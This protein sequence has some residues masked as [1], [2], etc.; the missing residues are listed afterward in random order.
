MVFSRQGNALIW[1]SGQERIQIES[2]GPSA[3]RV[4]GKLNS[5]IEDDPLNALLDPIPSTPE[6]EIGTEQAC[7]QN[8][9]LKAEISEYGVVRFVNSSTNEELLAEVWQKF[10]QAER[11]F[12]DVGGDFFRVQLK[13]KAYSDERFYGLGQYKHGKLDQKGCVLDLLQLN[14]EVSIPFLLSNRGYGFLWNNPAVGRVELGENQTRWIAESTAKLDYWITAGDTPAQIVER[15]VD[16]T[17]HPPLLP[18]WAAG[19]WQCKLR[20]KSQDEL[21]DI[22]RSYKKR[23]LPLSVIVIDYFH[24]TMQGDWKFDSTDW[25]D[26]SAMVKE[27]EEMG[28]K[29]M[30]SVWP[31]VNGAS[32]NYNTMSQNGLMVETNRG[33]PAHWV[34]TDTNSPGLPAPVHFY[35]ATN[36][37]AQTFI[38]ERIREGYYQH[39]IK[40]YWLDACEPEMYPTDPENLR[41][42]LGNGL[43]VTNIYPQ[44]HA[45]AFYEGLKSEGE[46]EIITLCRSAWAGSQKYGAAVWSGDIASTFEALQSQVRAGLNIGLS[47]IPW[48]TTDIG[49]FHGGDP[50]SPYFREL[51]IRWFQYGVF[52]PLFRLHGFR[53]PADLDRYWESGGPNEV[54]SF[55][56]E[57]YKIITD[58]L[59]LRERLRPYIME[60]MS[61]AH[62][63]G[64]PPMRPLFYDFPDD[65]EAWA[66]EDQYM[67]GPDL[68]VAP[69][70][71]EGARSR[72]VYLP[73]GTCWHDAWTGKILGAGYVNT[74][75]ASLNHIPLYVRGDTKLPILK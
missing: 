31:T 44:V 39:G 60:Q 33:I 68:L 46:D 4:R 3:F 75:E 54:W 35:D 34:L 14:S 48:W 20:Y 15:Y 10:P 51:I 2:W 41:Y 65:E 12:K 24:W 69:I 27:L 22:A 49:G 21:L 71:H 58:L 64:T 36:P 30:V 73:S 9:M 38:W 67:F 7:I 11:R 53:L 1:K 47:G 50:D 32:E 28:I 62:V 23:G 13:F 52:C 8:G 63:K 6:I 42:H 57:A 16:A 70:L 59:H 66:V 72:E 43:A 55:G 40:T 19:F 61:A 74:V 18:E 45:R 37:E 25:P 56:D 26:P 29:T 17:G 5:Q